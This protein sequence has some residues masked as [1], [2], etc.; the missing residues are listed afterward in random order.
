MLFWASLDWWVEHLVH[1]QRA[2]FIVFFTKQETLD[3]PLSPFM[4]GIH[5]SFSVWHWNHDRRK[6]QDLDLVFTIDNNITNSNHT[7][8]TIFKENCNQTFCYHHPPLSWYRC[9][10]NVSLIIR[11]PIFFKPPTNR[12]TMGLRQRQPKSQ[13]SHSDFITFFYPEIVV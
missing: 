9:L 8:H 7:D 11:S 6:N 4:R 12:D 13:V 3:I 1:E 5:R 10:I 2:V